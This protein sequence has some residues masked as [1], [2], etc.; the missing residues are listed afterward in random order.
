MV[1]TVCTIITRWRSARRE[2]CDEGYGMVKDCL[3]ACGSWLRWFCCAV[4]S[5]TSGCVG[6]RRFAACVVFFGKEL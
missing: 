2:G 3:L 5:G 6:L 4:T 1:C